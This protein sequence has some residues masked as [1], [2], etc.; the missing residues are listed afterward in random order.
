[1]KIVAR[2]TLTIMDGLVVRYN[3]RREDGSELWS[4][5]PEVS[6]SRNGLLISGAWP[7]LRDLGIVY[8]M[9]GMASARAA[10]LGEE[11]P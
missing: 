6:V 8:E 5:E 10:A 9:L 3:L 1:M 11:K 2:E 7:V 4:N